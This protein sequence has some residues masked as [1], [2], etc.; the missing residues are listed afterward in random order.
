M[1]WRNNKSWC[2]GLVWCTHKFW[3]LLS[4]HQ[5]CNIN[6]SE[7]T[8]MKTFLC[9]QLSAV[10]CLIGVPQCARGALFQSRC[11]LECMQSLKL[12][13]CLS[14][15]KCWD[16]YCC[17]IMIC[18]NTS[19]LSKLQLQFA[20]EYSSFNN[21]RFL[22]NRHK[23]LE[24]GMCVWLVGSGISLRYLLKKNIKKWESI[25]HHWSNFRAGGSTG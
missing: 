23:I 10:C 8:I 7:G 4:V 21:G 16:W 11:Y 24:W 9:L 15:G 12:P 20:I 13:W 22:F 18:I 6:S 3:Y 5:L 19:S 17:Q 1:E 25:R 14:R 2:P